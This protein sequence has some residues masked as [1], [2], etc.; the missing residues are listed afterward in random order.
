[1]KGDFLRLLYNHLHMRA[2]LDL[3]I[4]NFIYLDGL[5]CVVKR[6]YIDKP[7]VLVLSILFRRSGSVVKF[8]NNLTVS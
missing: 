2:D 7:K 3:K 1:M 6:L 4:A 8:S 5:M